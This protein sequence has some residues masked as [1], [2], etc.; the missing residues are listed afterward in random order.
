MAQRKAPTRELAQL[1][2]GMWHWHPL[3]R[4][5]YRDLWRLRGQV[6]AIALVIASGVSVVV[7]SLTAV[8]ALVAAMVVEAAST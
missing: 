3:T 5:L 4:K 8:E 7:S 1:V 2:I 6:L